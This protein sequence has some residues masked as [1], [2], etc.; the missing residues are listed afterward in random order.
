VIRVNNKINIGVIGFGTIG[1]SVVKLLLEGRKVFRNRTGID[2]NLK[3]VCDKDLSSKRDVS[4]PKNM[5]T[6]DVDKVIC[7][8]DIDVVVELIGG[9]HP[10]KEIV[11]RSLA[12]GKHVVTANKLLLA[13]HGEVIF[14][15]AQELDRQIYFE[16]SVAGG[17][18]IVKSIRESMVGSG[19]E[20][21]PTVDRRGFRVR[22]HGRG[23]RCAGS[24][25]T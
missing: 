13:T 9:V 18:P 15:K 2:L 16:A 24:R 10:A 20:G 14:K 8:P 12:S 5:L 1:S 6:R 23:A 21:D 19:C 4:V 17:V 3:L 7:D 25:G 11:M 22:D